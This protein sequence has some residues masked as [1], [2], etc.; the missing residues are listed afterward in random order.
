M[1][2]GNR[3]NRTIAIS[4]LLLI[5]QFKRFENL[6]AVLAAEDEH[7]QLSHDLAIV[8]SQEGFAAA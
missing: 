3:P 2:I 5:Q 1:L 6:A 4:G 8:A 7:D